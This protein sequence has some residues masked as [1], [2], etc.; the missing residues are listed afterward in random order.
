[1]SQRESR[2]LF[3]GPWLIDTSAIDQP[4]GRGRAERSA[5]LLLLLLPPPLLLLLLEGGH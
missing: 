5:L 2:R 4:L 3:F 1:M